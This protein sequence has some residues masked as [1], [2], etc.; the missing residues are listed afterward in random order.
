[1]LTADELA[2]AGYAENYTSLNTYLQEN[3]GNNQW[4]TLSPSLLYVYNNNRWATM[5][6]TYFTS[7]YN[8]L[9]ASANKMA[10]RPAIS[11]SANVS[12]TGNGTSENPYVV[13]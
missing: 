5:W 1:M 7:K 12:V 2:F 10:V 8:G 13:E 9:N 11:L 6:T 4:W 3:T